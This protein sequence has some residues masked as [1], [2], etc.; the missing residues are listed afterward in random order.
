[1]SRKFVGLGPG[2][3][4]SYDLP[5]PIDPGELAIHAIG[6]LDTMAE[7]LT[8]SA[9]L[10]SASLARQATSY[11]KAL[12]QD[13]KGDYSGTNR[14]AAAHR[15]MFALHLD[16]QNAANLPAVV[17]RPR[18]RQLV[19]VPQARTDLVSRSVNYA[20]QLL[21]L[22]ASRPVFELFQMTLARQRPG[23]P[24]EK[25]LLVDATLKMTRLIHLGFDEAAET[26]RAGQ[27]AR[28]WQ[29]FRPGSDPAPLAGASDKEIDSFLDTALGGGMKIQVAGPTHYGN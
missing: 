12:F 10:V 13:V 3:M 1:M 20:D 7:I 6:R 21:E 11:A 19:I 15:S 29:E 18:L 27:R 26:F 14:I 5:S 17:L 22:A 9:C 4:D 2:G 28:G 25:N 24:V 23:T 16:G 8:Q